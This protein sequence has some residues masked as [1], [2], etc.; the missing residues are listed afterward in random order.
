[1]VPELPHQ[2]GCD[3]AFRPS[4]PNPWICSDV[5]LRTMGTSMALNASTVQR[6]SSASRKFSTVHMRFDKAARI[7]ARW[8]MDLSPGTETLPFTALA[9]VI[10]L[11]GIK[12]GAR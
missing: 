3:G 11:D 6:Q 8:E 7:T 9:G 5:P 10:V 1:M 4:S 12:S 2:I